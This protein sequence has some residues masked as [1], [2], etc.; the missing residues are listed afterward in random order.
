LD[1]QLQL[2]NQRAFSKMG[3]GTALALLC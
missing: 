2:V 3:T 1:T